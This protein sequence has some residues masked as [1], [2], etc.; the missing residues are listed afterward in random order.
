MRLSNRRK[1]M[2][3]IEKNLELPPHPARG[4]GKWQTLLKDMEIGDP[5]YQTVAYSDNELITRLVGA[6]QELSAKVETLEAE[7]A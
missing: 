1:V 3:T 5:V 2:K 4:A 6:V 7:L